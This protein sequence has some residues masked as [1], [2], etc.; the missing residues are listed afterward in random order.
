MD[1][2]LDTVKVGMGGITID[3]TDFD[4]ILIMLINSAFST[5]KQLGVG[6]DF[7]ISDNTTEWSAYGIESTALLNMVKDYVTKKTKLGFDAPMNS[8]ATQILKEDIAQLEW[9][10]NV[11][12]DP[13]QKEEDV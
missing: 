9:R 4:P 2:I 8:S 10:M 3:N 11:Y 6:G 1:S 7:E 13:E 12:V 5:L